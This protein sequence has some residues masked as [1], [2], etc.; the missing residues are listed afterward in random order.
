MVRYGNTLLFF[1]M[2]SYSSQR[3]NL[4]STKGL[5]VETK[6]SKTNF[7]AARKIE[8]LQ[9]KIQLIA[10]TFTLL[11]FIDLELS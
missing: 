10:T 2:V 8:S 4:G 9:H 1:C 7:T 11:E 6:S 5:L 3:P